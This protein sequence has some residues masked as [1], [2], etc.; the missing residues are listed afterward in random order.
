MDSIQTYL[1]SDI[2]TDLLQGII[3]CGSTSVLSSNDY[4]KYRAALIGE[5]ILRNSQRETNVH[6]HITPL[7]VV[8]RNVGLIHHSIIAGGAKQSNC[9]I[10]ILDNR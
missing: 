2:R 5:V 6:P 10:A 3:R 4:Y 8:S 1:T 9:L 7:C